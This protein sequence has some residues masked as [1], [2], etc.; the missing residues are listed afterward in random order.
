MKKI[1]I[2]VLN[3]LFLTC[4]YVQAQVAAPM[5]QVIVTEAPPAAP[6]PNIESP[7]ATE[8]EIPNRPPQKILPGA[9]LPSAKGTKDDFDYIKA[10]ISRLLLENKKLES[11]YESLK[12]QVE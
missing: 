3:L 7:Q 5:G 10:E 9:L 8:A 6:E 1:V 12:H 4:T 11:E 2:L